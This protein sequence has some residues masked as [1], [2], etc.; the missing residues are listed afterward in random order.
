MMDPLIWPQKL[1]RRHRLFK[2]LFGYHCKKPIENGKMRVRVD[3]HRPVHLE[4]EKPY[5]GRTS[6]MVSEFNGREGDLCG[7]W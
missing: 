2:W 4:C 5:R 6:P 1:P 7:S 3:I